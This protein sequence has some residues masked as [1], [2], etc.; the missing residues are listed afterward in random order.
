M[1]VCVLVAQ[2]CLTLCDPT[3]CSPPGSFVR[4][5]LQARTLEWVAISFSKKA[6]ESKI[7]MITV[8]SSTV[9]IRCDLLWPIECIKIDVLDSQAQ[10]LRGPVAS[11]FAF[12]E[13]RCHVQQPRLSSWEATWPLGCQSHHGHS[14]SS[15]TPRWVAPPSPCTAEIKPYLL[16]SD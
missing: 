13:V 8:L 12:W 4:G 16:N 3:D 6:D 11:A 1:C 15:K 9:A 10:A 7:K 2:S 14:S 5:I